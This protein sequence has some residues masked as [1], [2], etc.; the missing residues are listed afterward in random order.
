VSG[1]VREGQPGLVIH[2]GRLATVVAAA[3]RAES[4]GFG[5]VWTTEFY[6]RSAP[7][8]LAAIAAATDRIRLGSAIMYAVGRSPLI[9]A[10]EAADLA[11]LS[12][13]R[14]TLGLGVGTR[15]MQSGW[16]GADPASPAPRVEELVPL[17][18][19]IWSMGPDGVRHEGRFYRL[20]LVPTGYVSAPLDL[21]VQLAAV[22]PRMVTAAGRVCDGLIGHPLFTGPYVE[23][24]VRPNLLGAAEQAGRPR[25][26]LTGYVMCAIHED[27]EQ[28]RRDAKAQIAFYSVVRTYAPIIELSGFQAQAAAARDAWKRNDREGMIAAI[29]DEM[30]DSIAVA[31][32][33]DEVVDRL[34]PVAARYDEALLY[35][36][37]FGLPEERL[38]D[39]LDAIIDTFASVPA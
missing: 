25:P 35:S 9:L 29:S 14:F 10:A 18:R 13:G 30:C 31:G 1:P 26:A 36:P 17:L 4:A 7:V 6:D 12:N 19:R 22:N 2:G 27:Q 32:T 33:A 8:S 28:A 16:H 15:Q 34:G 11:Q 20:D 38:S 24:V 3:C 23:E 5:S 21:R 39:N 37:S